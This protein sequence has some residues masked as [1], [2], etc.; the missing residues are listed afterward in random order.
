VFAPYWQYG[1][2]LAINIEEDRFALSQSSVFVATVNHLLKPRSAYAAV[3]MYD[4]AV[5]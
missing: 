1:R 5:A 3:G 2:Q 4:I